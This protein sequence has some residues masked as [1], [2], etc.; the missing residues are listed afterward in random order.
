VDSA[1]HVV[2]GAVATVCRIKT[3]RTTESVKMLK[4]QDHTGS[5]TINSIPA[6]DKDKEAEVKSLVDSKVSEDLPYHVFKMDRKTAEEL[7]KL[8]ELEKRIFALVFYMLVSPA[9]F[10]TAEEFFSAIPNRTFTFAMVMVYY[11]L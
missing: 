9:G 4:V 3:G 2:K 5:I 10:T 8:S 1:L 7:Y 6:F 11:S